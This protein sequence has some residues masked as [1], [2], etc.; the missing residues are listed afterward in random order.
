MPLPKFAPT[1]R[2]DVEV[3]NP[4]KQDA[5]LPE[6]I[7]V[8][9]P[10]STDLTLKADPR[11]LQPGKSTRLS[12]KLVTSRGNALPGEEVI[13]EQRPAGTDRT[14]KELAT[15]T[16]KPD[17]TFRLSSVEPSKYTVY[18]ARFAGDPADG[19]QASRASTLVRVGR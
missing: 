18:R 14:F 16:T 13:L 7:R 6:G 4:D 15:L 8:L 1:G 9:A 2:Y 3:T 5:V 10:R 19:F 17:G 12:G 11:T